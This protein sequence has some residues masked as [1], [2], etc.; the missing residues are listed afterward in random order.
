VP[1]TTATRA[2][3]LKAAI[4]VPHARNRAYD[5]D[6]DANQDRPKEDGQCHRD[7][8]GLLIALGLAS[9]EVIVAGP[10]QSRIQRQ[11]RM[12][13]HPENWGSSVP[14]ERLA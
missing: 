4:E 8:E 2:A 5:P 10:L 6:R 12:F 3:E 13:A 7:H 14:G 9:H 11:I 1:A